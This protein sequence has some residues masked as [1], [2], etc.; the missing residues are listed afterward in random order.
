[1]NGIR[2]NTRVW[3]ENRMNKGRQRQNAAKGCARTTE[4]GEA[5]F[6]IGGIEPDGGLNRRK[7]FAKMPPGTA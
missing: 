3:F 6:P 4:Q 1:M 5:I 2:Q 7:L